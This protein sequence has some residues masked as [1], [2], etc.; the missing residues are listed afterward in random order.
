M[1]LINRSSLSI[2]PSSESVLVPRNGFV[3][4]FMG[5]HI[6]V[7]VVLSLANRTGQS[8]MPQ[9]LREFVFGSIEATSKKANSGSKITCF[10]AHLRHLD[11]IK[12][13]I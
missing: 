8:F 13:M 2:T 10:E 4:K 3:P 7:T 11:I 12:R 6:N 9:H 5:T 1:P